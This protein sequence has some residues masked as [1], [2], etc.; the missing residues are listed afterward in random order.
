MPLK[1]VFKKMLN[2]KSIIED[3]VINAITDPNL[4]RLSN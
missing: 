2:K 1:K 4:V 3:R